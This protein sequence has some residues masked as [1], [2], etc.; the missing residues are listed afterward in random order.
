MFHIC[1][2][3]IMASSYFKN[4]L[5]FFLDNIS[6][7]MNCKIYLHTFLFY[8]HRLWCSSRNCYCYC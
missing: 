5:S 1:W 6:V 8:Y 4:L 3:F 7:S 2:I